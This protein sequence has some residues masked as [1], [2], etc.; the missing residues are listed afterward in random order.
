MPS[1]KQVPEGRARLEWLDL[2]RAAAILMV[3]AV[4]TAQLF[5]VPALIS[6]AFTQG[7]RGV[8]LFFA[9]SGFT[10]ML[11]LER[12]YAV[13]HHRWLAFAIRRFFR[14][15]PLYWVAAL[16]WF[17]GTQGTP[18][19]WSPD[20]SSWLTL[21]L[22]MLFVSN[23][24]P[25]MHSAIVPGGWSIAAEMNMY[26]LMP[27]LRRQIG[28]PKAGIYFLILAI[29]LG[30]A[31]SIGAYF[32]LKPFSKYPDLLKSFLNSYW[33]PTCLPSF[34]AGILAYRIQ[35]AVNASFQTKKSAT[36]LVLV[37]TLLVLAMGYTPLP[38]KAVLAAPLFGIVVYGFSQLGITRVPYILTWIGK[39]SYS[40]Y[41]V[42]F[43]VLHILQNHLP[44][45]RELFGN[46]P[47]GWL[48]AQLFVLTV[49]VLLSSVSFQFL[50]QP[51]I[52]LGAIFSAKATR[53]SQVKPQTLRA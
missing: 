32:L 49:T 38:L 53:A 2:L 40:A 28:N 47:G 23:W 42:H 33:L 12:E 31:L 4:H 20:G 17:F 50:E 51:M 11:T 41:F 10:M 14:I 5:P 19:Y 18:N 37:A 39:V 21:L 1:Q 27:W 48:L 6:P 29:F 34:I 52:K 13:K 43:V 36:A 35:S 7:A 9:I 15:V 26:C 16:A 25:T 46:V 22:T 3:I 24:L 45:S 44:H 8:Q 30:I